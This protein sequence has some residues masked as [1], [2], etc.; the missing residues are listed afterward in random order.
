V[1]TIIEDIA[2]YSLVYMIAIMGLS[3]VVGYAGIFAL[4]QG[5]LF[6]IGGFTFA[7]LSTQGVTSELLIAVPIAMVIG[8]AV[9][10]LCGL[11]VLRLSGDYY[12]VA[13][14]GFQIVIMQVIVNWNSIS[15]GPPGLYGLNAPTLA[16]H[17][18]NNPENML[19]VLIPVAII[20]MAVSLWLV[21]SPYGRVLLGL[22]DDELALKAGGVATRPVKLGVFVFA[23]VLAAIAGV[24]YVAYLGIASPADFQLPTSIAMMSMVLVGGAG[25]LW[26]PV[27][28]AFILSSMPYWLNLTGLTGSSSYIAGSVYGL[29]LIAVA[30]LSPDGIAGAL[31]RLTRRRT[32]LWQRAEPGATPT[33]AA[34][35]APPGGAGIREGTP[36]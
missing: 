18:I 16:G 21:K 31:R 8:G 2:I 34:D 36:R 15:G 29:V 33:A 23:G 27:I 25:S 9:S 30:F 14:L 10:L 6:G 7:V 28:G 5:A 24:L 11:P 12:L 35:S 4:T 22:A 17:A 20:L 1:T 3:L 19:W 26:G 32:L 13:S